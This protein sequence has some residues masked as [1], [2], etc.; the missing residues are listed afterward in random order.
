MFK[1]MKH[2]RIISAIGIIWLVLSS[3]YIPHLIYYYPFHELKGVKSLAEEVARAQRAAGI[4]DSTQKELEDSLTRELR[5]LWV[6]SLLLV[7]GGF[8]CGVFLL[9]R[10]QHGHIIVLVFAAGLFLLR[11]IYFFKHWDS[12]TSPQYWAVFFKLLP[13]Q[14]IQNITS[15]IVLIVTIFLLFRLSIAA[16]FRKLKNET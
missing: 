1:N 15:I 16:Q 3:S 4:N 5:V 8:L 6:K 12:Q 14:A 2:Q 11:V 10:G 7:F 9:K 13:L